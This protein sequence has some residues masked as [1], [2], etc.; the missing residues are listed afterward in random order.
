MDPCPL[1]RMA[2]PRRAV[3]RTALR[4]LSASA[5]CQSASESSEYRLGSRTSRVVHQNIEVAQLLFGRLGGEHCALEGGHVRHDGDR[6]SAGFANACAH[7][8]DVGCGACAH[9]DMHTI[10]RQHNR[11]RAPDAASGA[12]HEGRGARKSHYAPV[13]W[14]RSPRTSPVASAPSRMTDCIC[15][16]TVRRTTLFMVLRGRAATKTTDSGTS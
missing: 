11:H 7:V 15:S 12:G 6:R 14:M 8:V 16:N 5:S 4:K 2:G 13:V 3:V 1:A 9:G 10:G